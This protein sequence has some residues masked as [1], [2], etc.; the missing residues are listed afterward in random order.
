MPAAPAICVCIPGLAKEPEWTQDSTTY[1]PCELG[2]DGKYMEIYTL[3]YQEMD[4]KQAKGPAP[5]N[6]RGQVC[7]H[8][9]D[10]QVGLETAIIS[11]HMLSL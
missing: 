1:H 9:F 5:Q 7:L 8:F 11:Y 3:K 10:L 4:V 2:I 6:P